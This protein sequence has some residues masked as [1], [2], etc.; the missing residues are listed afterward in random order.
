MIGIRVFPALLFLVTLVLLLPLQ[1]YASQKNKKTV[2]E[3]KLEQVVNDSIKSSGRE[4]IFQSTSGNLSLSHFTWGVDVGSSIDLTSH[5]M[6]TF[7]V[8]A[9]LGF[10][11]SFI[12]TAGIGI[13][14]HRSVQ[15]GDNFIPVY[16]LLRTSFTRRPSL[17]FFNLR[18]GYS[19]N[20]I[21]DSPCYGDFSTAAGIGFNLSSSRMAK[22]YIIVG[23]GYR[24]FKQ[25]H[26]DAI[27]K[28]DTH[29]IFLAQL[30]FGVNF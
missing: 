7:D 17:C 25:R 2:K 28:L 1:G 4:A 23:A 15:S 11:N 9:V 26:I 18:V 13:G 20:T 6:S 27:D 19:F 24:Y 12:K 30:Q 10:K 16:A 29:Y 5:D 3:E 22:T 14:I 8:D 21:G